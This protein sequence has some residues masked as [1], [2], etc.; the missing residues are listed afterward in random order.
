MCY[1]N[2][3]SCKT[4]SR[5]LTSVMGTTGSG[6]SN[7]I[8]ALTNMR[9]EDGAHGY[10]SCTADV[11][12]YPCYHGGQRYIF[13][14]TPGFNATY[15]SQKAVFERI[16]KWLAATYQESRLQF[17][18][19]I[20]TRRITETLCRSERTSFRVC[21]HLIGND[22]ADRVRLVTTM[23]DEPEVHS[24]TSTAENR[25]NKLKEEQWESLI[26][27]GAMCERFFNTS[28]SAWGIVQR[29]G[30]ERKASLLLQRELVDMRKPL[31]QTTAGMR[32]HKESP[33]SLR[34]L[35]RR[36]FG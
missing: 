2:H 30:V 6:M 13:V 33:S 10:I 29:L 34:G 18:G 8:N 16:A 27:A 21:A 32:L 23:W 26:G 9:P 35:F 7:F 11:I 28:D 20:Y 3:P 15:S 12:A 17:N 22:V 25:E 1:P 36:L 5:W 31:K 19:V 24:D 14:D 4:T